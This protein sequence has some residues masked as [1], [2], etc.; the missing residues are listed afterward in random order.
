[1]RRLRPPPNA[2]LTS[3][4]F[5]NRSSLSF[6]ISSSR[7]FLIFKFSFH[8]TVFHKKNIHGLYKISK[9]SFVNK[10]VNSTN[11]VEKTK[12]WK[13]SFNKQHKN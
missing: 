2:N 9:I 12:N 13:R 6:H 5:A 7:S 10:I 4:N 3:Q 11:F 8:F 1:L